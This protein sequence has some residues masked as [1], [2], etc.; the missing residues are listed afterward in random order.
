M[1]GARDN[2]PLILCLDVYGDRYD[3]PPVCAPEAGRPDFGDGEGDGGGAGHPRGAG[4]AEGAVLFAVSAPAGLGVGRSSSG[5][6][7]ALWKAL[8]EDAH[9]VDAVGGGEGDAP[10]FGFG[11]AELMLA[12]HVVVHHGAGADGDDLQ[13]V[14]V[15]VFGLGEG[16]R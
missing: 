16:V 1:G 4:G 15:G 2:S 9:G 6:R 5:Q 11:V 13:G 10:L 3:C 12:N 14:V 8:G 7:L